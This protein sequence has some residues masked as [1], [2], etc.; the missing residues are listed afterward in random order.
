VIKRMPYLLFSTGL[1]F[2]IFG[3]VIGFVAR[4]ILHNQL[5]WMQIAMIVGASLVSF[6]IAKNKLRTLHLETFATMA[7]VGN[8]IDKRKGK[9]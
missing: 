9:K 7:E 2:L 6:I 3:C 5:W 4:P 1:T 8:A